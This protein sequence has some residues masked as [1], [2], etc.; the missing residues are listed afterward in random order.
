MNEMLARLEAA[1]SR[2]RRFVSDASHELRRPLAT[3]RHELELLLA[4]PDRTEVVPMAEGLMAESLRMQ[5]LVDDLLLLARSDEGS[6]AV[7]RRAVDLD[8]LV[9]AEATRLRSR[10]LVQVD[11]AHVSAGQVA[12]SR[13]T[14]SVTPA[15]SSASTSV[16]TTGSWCSPSTMTARASTPP[17]A[18][19]CSSAS[20]ASTPLAGAAPGAPASASR[21]SPRWLPPTTARSRWTTHP[22]AVPG[23]P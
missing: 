17:I 9:L 20:P 7:R 15:V 19:G 6:P 11:T 10:A 1:R 22:A 13:T 18:S 23:S 5:A 16:A 2:Q 4:D 8:D 21:S 12:T 3:I 14:P